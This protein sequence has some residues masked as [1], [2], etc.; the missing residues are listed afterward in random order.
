[1]LPPKP[2]P[3]PMPP[4][5]RVDADYV[6]KVVSYLIPI[7]FLGLA[8]AVIMFLG[9]MERNSVWVAGLFLLGLAAIGTHRVRI[10]LQV[11]RVRMRLLGPPQPIYQTRV[12][13]DSNGSII[14]FRSRVPLTVGTVVASG[15][16]GMIWPTTRTQAQA[17]GVVVKQTVLLPPR[18]PMTVLK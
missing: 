17:I 15:G 1:M 3:K 7:G 18:R 5:L 2:Y 6:T 9:I 14:E 8:G 10:A 11:H 13:L 4:K 12:Q 16:D